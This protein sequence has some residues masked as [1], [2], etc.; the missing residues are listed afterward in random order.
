[1]TL[2]ADLVTASSDVAGTSSRSGKIAILA[3]LLRR[4]DASEVTIAATLPT[5]ATFIDA[6]D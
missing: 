6:V 3:D 1:M 5:A 2:L 4:L